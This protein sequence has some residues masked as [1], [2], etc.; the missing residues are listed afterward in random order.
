MAKAVTVAIV[1]A[2]SSTRELQSK[3]AITFFFVYFLTKIRTLQPLTKFAKS[4]SETCLAK[5]FIPLKNYIY[6]EILLFVVGGGSFVFSC[7]L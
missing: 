6:S 3:L 5:M 1:R 7:K 4:Y 2:V